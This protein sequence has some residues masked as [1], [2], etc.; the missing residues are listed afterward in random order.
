MEK[1]DGQKWKYNN[2]VKLTKGE[3]LLVFT[4]THVFILWQCRSE[5]TVTHAP[6]DTQTQ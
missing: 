3:C 6:K 5:G 4:I 2:Y 1:N